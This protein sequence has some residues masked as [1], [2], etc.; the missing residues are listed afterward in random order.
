MR[1]IMT[2]IA[3]TMLYVCAGITGWGCGVSSLI[4]YG[5][6]EACNAALAQMVVKQNGNAATGGDGRQMIAFCRPG[7]VPSGK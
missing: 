7:Y 5:T 1:L 4:D 3:A 6:P 2:A